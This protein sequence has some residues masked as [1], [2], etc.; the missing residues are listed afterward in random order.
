M[1]YGMREM[2]KTARK[3][4]SNRQELTWKLLHKITRLYCR[5]YGYFADLG[6]VVADSIYRLVACF[7]EPA[8]GSSVSREKQ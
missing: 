6:I 5:V 8:V 3:R 7:S 4:S 1:I 2:V